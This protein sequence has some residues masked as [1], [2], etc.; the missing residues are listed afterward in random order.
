MDA[1][2]HFRVQ[3]DEVFGTQTHIFVFRH[4]ICTDLHGNITADAVFPVNAEHI[5]FILQNGN[6][7]RLFAFDIC[8]GIRHLLLHLFHKRLG[9]VFHTENF[10][11]V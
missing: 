9:T 3:A 5:A 4:Q 7:D 1:E 2:D 6:I 10:A 8:L 11:E